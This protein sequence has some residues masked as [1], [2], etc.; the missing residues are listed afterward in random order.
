MKL[1][2][3]S[4][5]LRELPFLLYRMFY[6]TN[7]T[8]VIFD[9]S[10]Y[11]GK[12]K[13][14]NM[15]KVKVAATQ[16]ACTWNLEENL[17]KAEKMVR[18]AA[19]DGA[20]VILL[21][22]LFET[23]YFCQKQD[24]QY[25]DLA[26]APEENQA[27]AHFREI[28]KELDVVLPI[29]FFEKAGNTSFNSMAMI[30]ADGSILGIYRKTHIPDGLPYAEKFY[31]TPGDT[32][33]KVWNTK[34]GKIGVGICWDQWFPETARSMTLLG[35]EMLLYPTAIGNE[36]ILQHDSMP[37]WRHC[38]QGHAAANIM[39]V[40]ASNRVGTE[41]DGT[42]MTFYGSSF[43]AD[44]SGEIVAKKDRESEGVITAEFDLD[45]I[46]EKRRNWGVFRDRRPEMY[47]I[48]MTHGK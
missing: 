25:F 42:E 48:L 9:A 10:E 7:E 13:E 22:E 27:I 47:Q 15:R 36:P 34:Y 37:H 17:Q 46:A 43:I 45:E 44:E 28:A 35:A 21:Q 11:E 33:F 23:P 24:F 6:I 2:R 8:L 19:Q 12:R 38:M 40:I 30:D 18:E 39:P 3:G 1:Q 4:F 16:M 5:P 14:G 32:G 41:I 29:S 20:N 26:H 31:F